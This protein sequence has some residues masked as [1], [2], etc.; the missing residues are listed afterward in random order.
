M[1]ARE[2]IRQYGWQELRRE[3]M[4][5]LES[6][7]NVAALVDEIA[8]LNE[9]C[10]T[11]HKIVMNKYNGFPDHDSNETTLSVE[12]FKKEYITSFVGRVLSV[13]IFRKFF[14]KFKDNSFGMEDDDGVIDN[15][16]L[17]D[18]K[19]ITLMTSCTLSF[20]NTSDGTIVSFRVKYSAKNK[21]WFT[22]TSK[23]D[24]SK[25]Y[26]RITASEGTE[27]RKT[28]VINI[29]NLSWPFIIDLSREVLSR[30]SK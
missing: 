3:I 22:S 12:E 28:R 13:L 4:S 30:K 7:Y 21:D 23:V 20:T 26:F 19:F 14:S 8:D 6:D 29:S 9:N 17:T 25:Y 16:Q 15:Y 5:D 18:F 1:T 27:D 11:I 10:S 24:L 2:Y